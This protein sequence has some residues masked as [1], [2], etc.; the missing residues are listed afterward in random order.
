MPIV[1]VIR[2]LTVNLKFVLPINMLSYLCTCCW[3]HQAIFYIFQVWK[4]LERQ[5]SDLRDYTDYD[6]TLE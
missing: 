3:E 2:L 1:E 4:I 5:W 6:N